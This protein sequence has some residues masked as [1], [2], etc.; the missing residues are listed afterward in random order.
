MWTP[1]RDRTGF[2]KA[3]AILA[4]ILIVSLGMCGLN[5]AVWIGASRSDGI[6]NRVG[7]VLMPLAFLEAGAI[8]LS[9]ASL[10]VA[11]LAW[12]TTVMVIHFRRADRE[13]QRLLEPEQPDQTKEEKGR[14]G[15]QR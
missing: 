14:D 15:E 6:M 7:P 10:V 1:W 8:A 2:P 3:V 13:I 9:A 12:A 4:T 5:Y 11:L